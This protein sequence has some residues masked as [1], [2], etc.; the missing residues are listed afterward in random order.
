MFVHIFS[1]L[2]YMLDIYSNRNYLYT[3]QTY[4]PTLIHPYTH[5]YN[6]TISLIYTLILYY[7]SVRYSGFISHNLS[8]HHHHY[9]YYSL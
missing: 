3:T 1:K 8:K 2:Q 7:T 9:Y 6:Y 4:I 5:A